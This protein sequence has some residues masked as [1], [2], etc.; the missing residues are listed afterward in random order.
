MRNVKPLNVTAIHIQLPLVFS[1]LKYIRPFTDDSL[2]SS[3][4]YQTCWSEPKELQAS[5]GFVVRL[6]TFSASK[7]IM[8]VLKCQ[9]NL[10]WNFT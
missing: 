1:M 10:L 5:Q 9:K 7:V 3:L 4:K 6:H 2:S 8:A